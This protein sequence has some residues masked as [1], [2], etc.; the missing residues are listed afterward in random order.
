[1]DDLDVV[2]SDP[3]TERSIL[4]SL[5]W[6][7][8]DHDGSVRRQATDLT[9]Y[10]AALADLAARGL[11]FTCSRSRREL[12][13]AAEAIGAPHG[14]GAN[15]VSTPSMR[16][17][18]PACWGVGSGDLNHRLKLDPGEVVI[19]DRLLGTSRLEPSDRFGDPILWTRRDVPAY[20]LASVVDDIRFGVT[21]VVRGEDLVPSAALQQ[22]LCGLLGTKPPTWWHLPLILDEE[23]RRLAKRDGDLTLDA[24]RASGI[25]PE[26]VIGL[27]ARTTG[28]RTALAPMKIGSFIEELDLDRLAA[29]ARA[30]SAAGGHRLETEDL[31]W[32]MQ[33]TS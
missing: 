31:D 9:P 27:I 1:M 10:R 13:A 18:D 4:D 29:W 25:P 17:T 22:R 26:R 14:D 28:L 12:R 2:R 21:D 33:R 19:E 20:Q 32:L 8:I 3:R 11:V 6:L 15:I 5:A 16:P 7:G 30:G 24:L 23:G